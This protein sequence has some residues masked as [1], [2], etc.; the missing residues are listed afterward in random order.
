MFIAFI[1][2]N[3]II[4]FYIINNSTFF[5]LSLRSEFSVV[6]SATLSARD[7]RFVFVDGCMSYL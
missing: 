4:F 1:N 3:N 2:Y 7:V 5:V 6:V